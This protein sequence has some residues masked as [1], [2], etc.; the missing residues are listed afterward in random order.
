MLTN[1][2]SPLPLNILFPKE[3]KKRTKL[4]SACLYI[5]SDPEMIL[6]Q[7]QE[8]VQD[9]GSG[10]CSGQ[11]FGTGFEADTPPPPRGRGDKRRLGPPPSK[12]RGESLDAHFFL[13]SA[14]RSLLII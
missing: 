4:F 1:L 11:G 10:K 13:K 2:L 9:R 5:F 7:V 3:R 8:N 12:G 6:K 14:L